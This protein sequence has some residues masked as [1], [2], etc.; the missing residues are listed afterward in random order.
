MATVNNPILYTHVRLFVGQF[1]PQFPPGTIVGAAG[2]VVS[3]SRK[4][5]Q[6]YWSSV[7]RMGAI[8]VTRAPAMVC[9]LGLHA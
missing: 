5:Q 6:P 7:A 1:Q 4:I 2:G 8:G 3:H 9:S